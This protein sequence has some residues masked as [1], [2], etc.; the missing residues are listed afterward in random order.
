MRC[1]DSQEDLDRFVEGTISQ[2]LQVPTRCRSGSG[3]P[4][5]SCLCFFMTIFLGYACVA[6]CDTLLFVG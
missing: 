3:R 6:N 2:V 5:Y 1:P 4:L